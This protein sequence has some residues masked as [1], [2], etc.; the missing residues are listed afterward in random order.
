MILFFLIFIDDTSSETIVHSRLLI[1]GYWFV[2]MILVII[3]RITR[4]FVQRKLLLAGVGLR[5]TIIIGW[6]DKAFE[7]CDMVLKYP[8]LGYKVIGFVKGK[9]KKRGP[10]SYKRNKL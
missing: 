7:L 9:R 8:A 5:N 3:G 6:S 4:R 10:F 2:L 1:L